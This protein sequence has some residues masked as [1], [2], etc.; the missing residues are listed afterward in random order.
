M[1]KIADPPFPERKC[2]ISDVTYFF[3]I[4]VISVCAGC[5]VS[6][7]AALR[8]STGYHTA[9]AYRYDQN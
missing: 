9:R 8:C 1:G 5:M 7:A 3:L 6:C 4:L 2:G